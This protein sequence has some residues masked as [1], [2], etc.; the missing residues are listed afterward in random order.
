MAEKTIWQIMF[1]TVTSHLMPVV[2]T[3]EGITTLGRRDRLGGS[4]PDFDLG[5][6]QALQ[7]GIS[8]RHAAL[9][10]SEDGLLILD[11]SSTNGTWLNNQMLPPNQP[12]PLRVGDHI[13]LG[14]LDLTIQIISPVH[15]EGEEDDTVITN[16]ARP[17]E[18]EPERRPSLLHRMQA[19]N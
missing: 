17:P 10:I 7:H 1:N 14:T 19:R 4:Q 2:I 5:P 3:V 13:R 12:Y 8:R 16:A 9:L 11:L 15:P 6:L 18:P